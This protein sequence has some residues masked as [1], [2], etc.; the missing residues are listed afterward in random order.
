MSPLVLMFITIM[1]KY[2]HVAHMAVTQNDC[3]HSG[4][5]SSMKCVAYSIFELTDACVITSCRPKA[6]Q[7]GNIC[8]CLWNV[9][10]DQFITGVVIFLN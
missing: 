5:E 2:L 3:A 7:D 9:S 10:T 1:S 4:I 8:A 6:I